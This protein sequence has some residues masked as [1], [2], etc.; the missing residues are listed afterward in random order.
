MCRAE[1]KFQQIGKQKYGQVEV[2][3]IKRFFSDN[4]VL[5]VLNYVWPV[6]WEE[7]T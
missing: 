7:I 2:Y 1:G 5:G 6:H 3:K 4:D